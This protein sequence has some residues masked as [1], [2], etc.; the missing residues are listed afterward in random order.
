MNHGHH[1]LANGD[2]LL[3]NNGVDDGRQSAVA[4]AQEQPEHD[5]MTATRGWAYQSASGVNSTCM[6]DAQCLPNGNMLVTYSQS[7]TI[8]EVTPDRPGPW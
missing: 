8:H 1:L 5:D 6:G 7:G 2:F 4:G 3:F